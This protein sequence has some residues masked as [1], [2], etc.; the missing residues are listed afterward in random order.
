LTF[1]GD[2]AVYLYGQE[3]PAYRRGEGRAKEIRWQESEPPAKEGLLEQHFSSDWL[4][5]RTPTQFITVRARKMT[6]SLRITQSA[7]GA[8]PVVVNHLGTRIVCIAASDAAGI[9]FATANLAA[10]ATAT[11]APMSAADALK[12]I[13]QALAE[14]D[15]QSPAAA[16]AAFLMQQSSGYN[17]RPY[18]APY[19]RTTVPQGGSP[20][21]FTVNF[22]PAPQHE[23]VLERSLRDWTQSLGPQ[24]FVAIVEQSPEVA[25]G[26]DSV[27]EEA[28]LHVIAG[29]W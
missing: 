21:L 8:A 1:P 27:H 28:S 3:P 20:P 23:S 18:V 15:L 6:A 22:G 10:D 9:H 11:L 19:Y 16:Q 26:I 24:S 13:Q 12:P 5:S 17:P 7:A 25:L 2:V 4:P 14:N 29:E